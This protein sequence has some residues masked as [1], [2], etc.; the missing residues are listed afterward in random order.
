MINLYVAIPWVLPLQ[1]SDVDISEFFNA[2]KIASTSCIYHITTN[3]FSNDGETPVGLYDDYQICLY[4]MES[5]FGTLE[6]NLEYKIEEMVD[7]KSGNREC[8]DSL[9]IYTNHNTELVVDNICGNQISDIVPVHGPDVTVMLVTDRGGKYAMLSENPEKYKSFT[10]RDVLKCCAS[11]CDSNLKCECPDDIGFFYATMQSAQ[12]RSRSDAK[13]VSDQTNCTHGIL[14]GWTTW[15]S[16][17]EPTGV[18]IGGVYVAGGEFE[19]IDVLRSRFEFCTSDGILNVECRSKVTN[20]TRFDG[21]ISCDKNGLTC[22]NRNLGGQKCD[23]YEVRFFCVCDNNSTFLFKN[24]IC[25]PG[26]SHSVD[27]QEHTY[28]FDKIH[29]MVQNQ[30]PNPA[31]PAGLMCKNLH[32]VSTEKIKQ[33]GFYPTFECLPKFGYKCN[34]KAPCHPCPFIS[35]QIWYSCTAPTNTDTSIIIESKTT[36]LI[37]QNP[38]MRSK[39]NS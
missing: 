10:K 9:S 17:S 28:A 7:I 1:F 23:D 32:G 3:F 18:Q 26:W 8:I 14:E 36:P 21:S 33:N 29:K 31:Y 39:M 22:L 2:F 27:A 30:Q 20:G 37:L 11:D 16:A 35:L 5:P 38:G 24:G 13:S 15:M 12:K 6:L 34:Q 25:K 4:V 19:T